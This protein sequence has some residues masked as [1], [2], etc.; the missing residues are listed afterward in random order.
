[1]TH[2]D[3]ES[4]DFRSNA[5][6]DDTAVALRNWVA[7]SSSFFSDFWED[8]SDYEAQLSS[9]N[10]TTQTYASLLEQAPRDDFYCLAEIQECARSVWYMSTRDLRTICAEML[11]IPIGDETD[12]Q[13][14]TAVEMTLSKMFLDNLAVALGVGWMGEGK[15]VIEPT[16]LTKDPRK[17]GVMRESDLAIKTS[18]QV[19]LRSGESKIHWLLQKQRACDMFDT[20]VDKRKRTAPAKFSP[21]TVGKI[22]VELVVLLGKTSVPLASLSSLA[23]GEII[24]LDHRIDRPVVAEINNAPFYECWPGRQGAQQAVEISRTIQVAPEMDSNA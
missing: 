13:E 22:P 19:K 21:Q 15:A 8:A 9:E 5:A 18:I 16:E 11:D 12:D 2:A 6:L 14:L 10:V 23:E 24:M 1:M 20:V 17:A 7:K 4:F 3:L